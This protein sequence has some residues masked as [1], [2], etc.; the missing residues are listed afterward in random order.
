MKFSSD[1]FFNSSSIK[2]SRLTWIDFAKG[3][4][5]IM[6]VFRHIVIG[7][8]RSEI[9]IETWY[10]TIADITYSFRMPLFFILSGFFI[11]SS[12]LKR[13]STEFVTIKLKTLFYPYIIWTFIQITVQIIFSEYINADRSWRDYIAVFINPR[14]I[15]QFW[16]IY[17]LFNLAIVYL[18]LFRVTK[19]NKTILFAI[20]LFFYFINRFINI[21]VID[22]VLENF[23]Y[24]VIGDLVSGFVLDKEKVGTI[25]SYA[26]LLLF[27]LLFIVTQYFYLEFGPNEADNP[28][29]ME[30][31]IYAVIALVG[32]ILTILISFHLA[33]VNWLLFVRIAGFHSMYIYLMHTLIGA[34][35]KIVLAKVL[36]IQNGGMIALICTALACLIPIIFYNTCRHL[37]FNFLFYP[38][39]SRN[40]ELKTES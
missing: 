1:F 2:K 6:V 39:F 7:V 20:G 3:A 34:P 9:P 35:I 23:V 15:D 13:T 4:A 22:D 28:I 14:S 8:E 26:V 12:L 25:K 10:R 33:N 21:H 27:S 29:R 36:H 19:G 5:I 18:F 11:R 17:A 16:F 37:G 24:L 40:K 38:N 32:S 30:P 31:F